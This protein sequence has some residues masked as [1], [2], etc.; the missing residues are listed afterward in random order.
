ML[1]AYFVISLHLRG[2]GPIW[3]SGGPYSALGLMRAHYGP[4]PRDALRR[5]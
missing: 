3:Q 2:L 5:W 4:G 1:Y